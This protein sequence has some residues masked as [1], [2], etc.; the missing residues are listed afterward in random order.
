MVYKAPEIFVRASVYKKPVSQGPVVAEDAD[1]LPEAKTPYPTPMGYIPPT[2]KDAE[3]APWLAISP[4]GELDDIHFLN[5]SC[6]PNAALLFTEL[7]WVLNSEAMSQASGALREIVD[8]FAL[9]RPK[10]AVAGLY[11]R[12]TGRRIPRQLAVLVV[13]KP[14]EK[15]DEITIDYVHLAG[16][17]GSKERMLG[18]PSTVPEPP[19]CLWGYTQMACNCA[20]I[21]QVGNH[22][23]CDDS[24]K[25]LYQE[26]EPQKQKLFSNYKPSL[27]T[28]FATKVRVDPDDAPGAGDG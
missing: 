25:P 7:D 9:P 8:M 5:H 17:P 20:L 15:G 18:L 14:V 22:H 6:D 21:E 12:S 27:I 26:P 23:V 10:P 1:N 16:L 24:K 13:T 19:K 2:P 11:E 4:E 28:K 3:K